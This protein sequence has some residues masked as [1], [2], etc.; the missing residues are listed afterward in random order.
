MKIFARF[1]SLAA[2]LMLAP[3]HAEDAQAALKRFVDGVQTLSAAFTQVQT[4]DKGKTTASSA[5]HMWLARPGRFRWS[6]ET[7]YQQLIVC[8]GQKIWL[9][10]Q[11][12]AQ[13]T[14]RPSAE[15][16]KDT[17]AELLSQRILL[18]DAFVLEDGGVKGKL[19]LV[20]L[21]PRSGDSDF[22]SIELSLDGGT[23]AR[24]KFFDQLGGTTDVAFSSV[25]V[26]QKLDET[27]F[28]FAPPKG[29]E[30]IDGA[31]TKK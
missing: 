19:H 23:P 26:N 18:S 9:Y 6:Y 22:K 15:A 5:G 31:A 3:A 29:T 16:L 21:K 24:M 30:V 27:Q 2:A 11:D 17:P 14:V 10:D 28:R 7:P 25:S 4:D 8:D 12:L 20:R 13:V 1:L